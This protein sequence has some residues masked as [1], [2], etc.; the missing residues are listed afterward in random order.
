M[1]K[2]GRWEVSCQQISE[3]GYYITPIT[4]EANVLVIILDRARRLISIGML[5]IWDRGQNGRDVQLCNANHHVIFH[6][7][8]SLSHATCNRSAPELDSERLTGEYRLE[9]GLA[10]DELARDEAVEGVE[11]SRG[12]YLQP[13]YMVDHSGT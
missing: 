11:F 9:Q 13:D 2:E 3:A 5:I 12:G 10:C 7:Y 6:A 1:V 8:G 4:N